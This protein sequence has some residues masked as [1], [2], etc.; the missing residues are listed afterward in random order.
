VSQEA[1]ADLRSCIIMTSGSHHI[2]IGRRTWPSAQTARRWREGNRCRYARGTLAERG[3]Q[4]W[5][6]AAEPVPLAPPPGPEHARGRPHLA[7]RPLDGGP[8]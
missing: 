1:L 8:L 6:D 2:V 3:R 7:D 4:V 5:T